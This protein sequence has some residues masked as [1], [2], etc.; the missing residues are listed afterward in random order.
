PSVLGILIF[1]LCTVTAHARGG[2]ELVDAGS[3]VYD[4]FAAISIE[5]GTVDFSDQAPLSVAELKTYFDELDYDILSPA[6]KALYRRLD[7]YFADDDLSVNFDIL[8]LG[9]RPEVNLEGYYKHNSKLPWCYDRY[10]K[11]PLIYSPVFLN[12]GDW[13]SL[14]MDLELGINKKQM[15]KKDDYTNVPLDVKHI[16]ADF[17]KTGYLSAGYKFTDKTGINFRLG[18]G[19]QEVGRTLGGSIIQSRYFTG[20]SW[21]NLEIFNPNVR[22]NMNVTQFNVDKYM[23]THRL[24]FRLFDKLSLSVQESTLVYGPMELRF[25]NPLTIFHGMH[26]W[27]DYFP[28]GNPYG[29]DESA[30]AYLA[31]KASYAVT[32]NIR[33][34]GL[35]AQ[36]QLQMPSE[37]TE[38]DTTPNAFGGQLGAEAFFPVSD[39]YIHPRLE[40]Y[41]ATPYLYIKES[42]NWSMARSYTENIGYSDT[43]D[44]L[45]EWI[46]SP[47]GPDTIAGK[48]S[49]GYEMPGRWSLTATGLVMAR[50]EMSGTKVFD[51]G[52]FDDETRRY[53]KNW[54]NRDWHGKDRSFGSYNDV[55]NWAF[56]NSKTQGNKTAKDRQ[57]LTTPSTLNGG[58]TEYVFNAAIKLAYEPFDYLSLQVQPSYTYVIN[59]GNIEGKTRHGPE[60]AISIKIK[61]PEMF[62]K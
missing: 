40:A 48:M 47:F 27:K 21:G 16:N 41:Y 57:G 59:S 55:K 4:A 50:G 32:N 12:L 15:E 49:V 14:D 17:P 61:I 30:C 11:Q 37:R 18:M 1:L 13:L 60:F 19:E 52:M 8:Q 58:A 3:W 5:S 44:A 25:L 23:Y 36:D 2:Q 46:G 38:N 43:E 9:A 24:D 7:E 56:P 35:Y 10:D 26:D 53:Y 20:S 54:Y 22:Y 29:W 6:G 28:A 39:G 31:L 42:P 62:R 51:D 34:Y 33:I 45:Y